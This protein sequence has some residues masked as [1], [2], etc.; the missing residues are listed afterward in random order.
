MAALASDIA[1][2]KRAASVVEVSDSAILS[3]FPNARDGRKAPAPGYFDSVAD[4]SAALAQKQ[5]I[6]GVFRRRWA[7]SVD[8]LVLPVLSAGVPCFTLV[9][10]EQGVNSVHLVARIEVDL[11]DE[12]TAMELF[13]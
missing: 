11:E 2:A 10:A 1:L 7:A 8:E 12:K 13:G 9:D 6:V 3:R 5:A 4:A